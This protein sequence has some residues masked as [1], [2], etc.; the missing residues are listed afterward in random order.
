MLIILKKISLFKIIQRLFLIVL[1]FMIYSHT[2]I[3]QNVIVWSDHFTTNKEWKMHNGWS[4][5][6][7][8]NSNAFFTL[9]D[10]S[11]V[12]GNFMLTFDD[13]GIIQPIAKSIYLF[14][15]SPAINLSSYS[16]ATLVIK[17][18]LG[19]MNLNENMVKIEVYDGSSWIRIDNNATE[20]HDYTWTES[21]FNIS[22]Y[23]NHDFKIRF[24]INTTVASVT[25]HCVWNID[26]VKIKTNQSL[27]NDDNVAEI[28]NITGNSNSADTSLQDHN[29]I[30][31]NLFASELSTIYSNFR[32]CSDDLDVLAGTSALSESSTLPSGVSVST[33]PDPYES[34]LG[35]ASGL[36]LEY[37][38]SNWPSCINWG[39]PTSVDVYNLDVNSP[40]CSWETLTYN[41]G[42]SDLAN[43]IIYFTGSDRYYCMSSTWSYVYKYVDV[44]MRVVVTEANGTT[45]LP[46]SNPGN[47]LMLHAKENFIVKAFIEVNTADL[48]N[49]AWG[50]PAN[51][52]NYYNQGWKGV[53]DVYDALHTDPSYQICTQFQPK[54]YTLDASPTASSNTPVCETTTLNLNGNNDIGSGC[55]F[56]WTGPNGFSST[57]EDPSIPGVSTAAAGTYNLVISDGS[58][59]FGKTS[60][61]VTIHTISTEPTDINAVVNP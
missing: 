17:S 2:L 4:I 60:T 14:A 18:R 40:T 27:F 5:K 12:N 51:A 55:Y 29:T 25:Q 33:S 15:S 53:V 13:E 41:S 43:G 37:T 24:G 58:A 1:F 49:C 46:I 22:P 16:N 23:I 20:N 34:A 9:N 19:T 39:L 52:N 61:T 8:T 3:S 35:N 59:C 56:N 47:Y 7:H 6:N 21:Q 36:T 38:S 11:N 54:W 45:P 30:A 44:R 10:T 57:Q 28:S 50:T 26:Y 32:G 48:S 31:G 42:S